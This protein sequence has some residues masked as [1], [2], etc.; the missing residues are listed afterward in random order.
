MRPKHASVLLMTA[1]LAV[2]AASTFLRAAGQAAAT[3]PDPLTALLTEVHALRI[4]MEQSATVAPRVQL[5]LAR[6]NIEEQRIAQ[7]VAQLDQARRELTAVSLE[8]Q[9]LSD[10]LP[11]LERGLQTATDDKARKSYD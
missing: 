8:S 10:Q 2:I 4:A 11:E 6:L 3:P 1:G 9:K 5:T 7:L